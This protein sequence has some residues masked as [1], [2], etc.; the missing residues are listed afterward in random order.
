MKIQ[1]LT[2]FPQMFSALEHSIIKRAKDKGLVEIEYIDFRNY[3]KDKHKKVDD[4]AFGGGAG[5]VLMAQPIIDCIETIDPLHLAHRI[6]LTPSAKNLT[7]KKAVELSKHKNLILLCGH[8]EG[9]DQRIID[10]VIDETISIGEYVLTGG[11]I[12]AMVIVDAVVRHIK[13]VISVG[14]LQNESHTT[15]GQWEY[16]QYTRPQTIRNLDVPPVLL[17][18]NHAE[19]E[20][21]KKENSVKFK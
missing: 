11:E 13:G 9:I 12:P 7:H 15:Q 5:L 14:S 16:P 20:K 18:G 19:I 10:L 1:I 6:Y 21:W 4:Y 8:Y 2:L 17:S 3:S